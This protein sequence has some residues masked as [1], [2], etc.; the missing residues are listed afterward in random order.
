MSVTLFVPVLNEREGL[1]AIMPRIPKN[2]FSQIL[3]VDGGS[4]DGSAEWARAQGYD[5]V[6]QTKKGLRHAYTEG[7][8]HIKS[9]WVLTFSPDGNCI[10][11]DTAKM[12]AK[13]EEGYDMVIGSR[14]APGATSEDDDAITGFGNWMFTTLIN[15]CFGGRYTDVMNI[16]RV[17]RAKAFYD[18]DIH[19][20][21][22][23]STEKLFFTV[24]GVEPLI[25]IRAAKRKF[26][27]ADVP[28]SEPKRI[29]GVR[30]LQIVRWGLAHLFQIVKEVFSWR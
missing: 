18:L 23:H 1:E 19:K 8:P 20:N 28:S 17:Y 11:E 12:V 29:H 26:K 21:E 2:V 6:V 13:L 10:P 24:V 25:S 14:Y 16:L 9:E 5:V 7:F 22:S 4:K 27:V 15:G 3:I 30:K